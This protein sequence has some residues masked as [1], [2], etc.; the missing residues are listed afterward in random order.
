[1]IGKE[2]FIKPILD[3]PF[4]AGKGREMLRGAL[5]AFV[6][7]DADLARSIPK[8]DAEVDGLY[9]QIHRELM[10]CLFVDPGN[11]EQANYLLWIA[12]NLERAA[13]WV[14]N[15][16]ERVVFTATGKMAELDTRFDS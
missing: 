13:D 16:C 7:S 12:H 2:P 6:R 1:M 15:T 10:T 5:D 8:Q 14:T 9:N 4:M 3:I 11:I